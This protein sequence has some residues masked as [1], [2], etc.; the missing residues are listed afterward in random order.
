[1]PKASAAM[2]KLQEAIRFRDEYREKL[3]GKPF[4]SKDPAWQ[5]KDVIVSNKKHVVDIYTKMFTERISN[6]FAIKFFSIKE[7]DF[8]VYVISHQWSAVSGVLHFAPID[9]Y[10]KLA[11]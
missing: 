7:N 9:G 11:H 5:I 6:E 3:T 8:Y 1:L 10:L 2:M 4:S